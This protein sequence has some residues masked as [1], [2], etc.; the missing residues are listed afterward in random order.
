MIPDSASHLFFMFF[1]LFVVDWLQTASSDL[2]L[3]LLMRNQVAFLTRNGT[4]ATIVGQS[5]SKDADIKAGKVPLS[6]K[7]PEV[8]VGS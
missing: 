8:L 6:H 1:R 2:P 5:M 7:S 4:E 3:K